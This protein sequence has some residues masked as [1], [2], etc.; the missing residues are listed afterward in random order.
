MDSAVDDDGNVASVF[1][2]LHDFGAFAGEGGPA[3]FRV[4]VLFK[5]AELAAFE[6]EVDLPEFLLRGGADREGCARNGDGAGVLD[7]D[8]AEHG[9]EGGFEIAGHG[10]SI[11]RNFAAW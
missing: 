3:G 9:A 4:G 6:A 5:G 1:E 11:G 7:H 8:L 10:S 2:E